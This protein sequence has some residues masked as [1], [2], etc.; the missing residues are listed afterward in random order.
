[1]KSYE[2]I[3]KKAGNKEMRKKGEK[4]N[5]SIDVQNFLQSRNIALVTFLIFLLIL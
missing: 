5:L 2:S 3:P 4:K 1:M